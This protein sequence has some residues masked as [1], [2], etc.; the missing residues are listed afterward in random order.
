M[1]ME[2]TPATA[3]IIVQLVAT[4]TGTKTHLTVK[5]FSRTWCGANTYR[6]RHLDE[7]ADSSAFVGRVSCRNCAGRANQDAADPKAVKAAERAEAEAAHAAR[8]A[9]QATA[10]AAGISAELDDA[11]RAFCASPSRET[12]GALRNVQPEGFNLARRAD[13][14]GIGDAYRAA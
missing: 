11:L 8:L 4:Q 9:E 6:L 13:E 1:G 10:Y 2:I 5:G 3:P 14:L 12:F 7:A